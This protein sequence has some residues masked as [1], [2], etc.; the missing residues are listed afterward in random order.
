TVLSLTS[1]SVVFS[2]NV[3][4]VNASDLLINNNPATS[5]SGAA[6]VYTFSFTQ[7]P[8]GVVQVAWAAGHG[9]TDLAAPPNA[10]AGGNWL[11]TLDPNAVVGSGPVI[12]EFLAHNASGP[13]ALL[14]ED[15]DSSDWIE[16]ENV[17]NA[18]ANLLDWSLTDTT[19]N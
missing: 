8:T 1:I 5:L 13:G 15:G 4:G 3:A 9:I 10:F 11:Y 19:N 7:P 14:D 6:N 17:G 16:I 12:S 18:T 2:E